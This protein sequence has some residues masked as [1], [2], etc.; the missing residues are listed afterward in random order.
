MRARHLLPFLLL[1]GCATYNLE[2]KHF[3]LPGPARSTTPPAI[4]GANVEDVTLQAADGTT[5][6]GAYV[7]RADAD[8]DILY[9]GGNE[10]RVD[11]SLTGLAKRAADL[12]ANVLMIDYRGY[13]RSAGTPT[14]EVL[15][16]DAL[17]A[18]DYLRGRSG[19]RPIVVH[20]FSLGSFMAAHV[21]ANRKIEGLVLEAT[22]PNVSTWARNQIPL[23]AKPVVRLKIAPSL[24]AQD[25]VALVKRYSGPLLI[26]T[27]SRDA[28][29][30]PEFMKP[31]LA[32]S[33]SAQKRAFVA[34]GA[35]HG[36][37]LTV[38][39]AMTA[40]SELLDLVR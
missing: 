29:T 28:V 30:P 11:D 31:L 27:G 20:G 8:V 34:E 21:A 33:P 18:L 15:K 26:V 37:A 2:E 5:L 23:Y 35:T 22:A 1:A 36:N 16:N 25:N 13:G 10:S 6:R 14:V 39:A 40:Y 38:P 4:T 17:A 32:A 9:F 12:R 19:N 3:L 24:L 7:T